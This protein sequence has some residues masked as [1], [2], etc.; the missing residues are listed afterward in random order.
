MRLLKKA[1]LVGDFGLKDQIC[2]ASVSVVL[3]M[4]EVL[5]YGQNNREKYGF[6]CRM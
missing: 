2:R 4:A 6:K 3:N 5:N 1:D